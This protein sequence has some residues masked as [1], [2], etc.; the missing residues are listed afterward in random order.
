MH[1]FDRKKDWFKSTDSLHLL[2]LYC[3]Y[4]ERCF[5]YQIIKKKHLSIH[6][7]YNKMKK[8]IGAF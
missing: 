3:V 8:K 6:K 5:N 4:S 7:Q 1:T 2:T